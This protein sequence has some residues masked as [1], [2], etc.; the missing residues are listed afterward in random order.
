MDRITE[1]LV[2]NYISN[3]ELQVNK[4]EDKFEYFCNYCIVS[5]EYSDTFDIDQI[6]LGD[7]A[8]G[9]DGIAI[10]V[11]GKLIEEKDEID[12][13]I[14]TNKYLE[15][16]FVFVQSKTA[17]NFDC[18][19]ISKFLFGVADFFDVNFKLPRSSVLKEKAEIMNYIYNNGALM[20]KGNPICKLYY[21]TTGTWK[22]DPVIAARFENGKQDLMQKNLFS[23]V[24][25]V[26]VDARTIQKYYQDTIT[27]ISREIIF[28]NKSLLPEIRG[29]E[30]A[31]IGT[32]EFKQFEKLITD[33]EGKIVSSIFY[34]NVRAFQGGDNPVNKKI[35]ETLAKR[36][37]DKFPILNNGITIVA[38]SLQVVSNKF[39][40]NDYSI[41][42]GCQ[43]SH[44]LFDSRN[45]EAIDTMSIP[46]RIIVTNDE[47]IRNEVIQSTNNQTQVR[48]E[49]L[50][51]LSDFQKILEQYY[52]TTKDD[53]QLFYERRS[54][55]FASNS[56]VTKTRIIT[57]PIQI[58]AFAAM[59]LEEPHLVSRFYGKIIKYLGEKIFLNDHKP[60][61]YYTTALAYF[62]LDQLFRSRNLDPKYK[63]CRYHLLMILPYIINNEPKPQ[64][65]SQKIEEYC[66]KIL[67]KLETTENAVDVFK[68]ATDLIEAAGI[69]IEHRDAFKLQPT[70]ETIMKFFRDNKR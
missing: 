48:P 13:L 24:V 19:E 1:S 32:L 61:V 8:V 37:F 30:Q 23:D 66:G 64:L 7:D 20:T 65:N 69:D 70:N 11:N 21:A 47:E 54:K 16:L 29:V 15:V 44:V 39:T 59:F 41:V 35:K 63:K 25:V 58:K 26:P 22:N 49:E 5:R 31:Y 67:S 51:A 10:I 62:R 40:L 50:S 28:N 6:T 36:E 56:S 18:G 53:T 45:I 9:I 43:T 57:V 2:E 33:E 34:D 42:N 12:D 46:V 55:Q 17:N 3:N 68:E 38:R 4:I 14:E 52:L 60:V 27:T